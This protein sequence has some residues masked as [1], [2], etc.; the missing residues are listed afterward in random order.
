M[1][2]IL[3]DT[4]YTSWEGSI[5][6][7]WSTP[8][9]HKEIVQ[10]SALKIKNNKIIEKY[11]VLVKPKHNPDLSN[12]F[13]KL[14]GITNEMVQK[15]GIPFKE[16]LRQFYKFTHNTEGSIPTYSYGNLYDILKENYDLHGIYNNKNWEKAFY[17]IK[18]L[19]RICGIDI[20]KYTSETVYKHF[21]PKNEKEVDNAT[22][23]VYSLY[24]VLS[25]I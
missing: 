16:F 24:L 4:K 6:R 22:W 21:Y 13:I 10:V 5:Q 7:N 12:H 11:N 9:E 14:T 8:G 3:W 25:K 2:L 1:T 20:D 17:D 23:N 15:N 18:H 19:F